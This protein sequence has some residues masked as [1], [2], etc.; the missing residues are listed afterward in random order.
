MQPG[1]NYCASFKSLL[2]QFLLLCSVLLCLL[3]KFP[4][5]LSLLYMRLCGYEVCPWKRP[6]VA[7]QSWQWEQHSGYTAAPRCTT[8]RSAS[9]YSSSLYD[10]TTVWL[11]GI[12][13]NM[14]LW[15]CGIQW[16]CDIVGY[17]LFKKFFNE[18]NASEWRN[19]GKKK[20]LMVMQM[21][22]VWQE[23]WRS[24]TYSFGIGFETLSLAQFHIFLTVS[25]SY[26]VLFWLTC[27]V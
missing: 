18:K 15:Y 21:G 11:Q 17:K 20:I 9:F 6:W 12:S 14:I 16:Y 13:W 7:L 3:W 2:E 19:D 5:S 8:W 10:G 22:F 27:L 26:T 25:V 24:E 23:Q 4:Y 1:L